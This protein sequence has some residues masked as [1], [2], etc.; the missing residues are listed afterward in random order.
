MDIEWHPVPKPTYKRK[1]KKRG[2]RGKFSSFIREQVKEHFEDTCQMCGGHGYHVHHVQP[3]G[4]GIGRGVFTNA[5]LLCASCHKKIHADDKLLRY[6]KDIYKKKYG[7]FYFMDA[8]DLRNKR[9]SNELKDAKREIEE[10][11][12][13]NGKF[14]YVEDL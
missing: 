3:K 8:D 9:L 6:W 1:N 14:D 10:W 5:L 7:P 4:S 12:K 2:D 13:Y 11:T